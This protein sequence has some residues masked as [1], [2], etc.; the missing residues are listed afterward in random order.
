[1]CGTGRSDGQS[2]SMAVFSAPLS[3]V[4]LGVSK[5]PAGEIGISHTGRRARFPSCR[6]PRAALTFSNRGDSATR[7]QPLP[8][9]VCAAET[10]TRKGWLWGRAHPGLPLFPLQPGTLNPR[11]SVVVRKPPAPGCLSAS[12]GID[13]DRWN[14]V[15]KDCENRFGR[16]SSVRGAFP[17]FQ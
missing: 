10:E 6:G 8:L 4:G 15:G 9:R 2:C 12:G 7:G 5:R 3:I 11:F 14:L 13:G 17:V 16:L 1:M